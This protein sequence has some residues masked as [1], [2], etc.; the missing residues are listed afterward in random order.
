MSADKKLEA[1][2]ESCENP[3]D[4]T[5]TF[6][7]AQSDGI[8]ASELSPLNTMLL[9]AEGFEALGFLTSELFDPSV[10]EG[11]DLGAAGVVSGTSA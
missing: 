9:D 5:S 8:D 7:Q 11:F 3:A 2:T 6:S 1:G 4:T 10:F